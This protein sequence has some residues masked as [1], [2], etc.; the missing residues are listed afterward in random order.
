MSA[1]REREVSQQANRVAPLQGHWPTIDADFRDSKQF[2]L[3]HQFSGRSGPNLAVV[4]ER[5][6]II[7]HLYDV[8]TL[9]DSARG[10]SVR[11][12]SP[13]VAQIAISTRL[14]RPSLFNT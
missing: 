2:E 13:R 12:I 8:G 10:V 3:E 9:P 7:N 1:L 4:A 6:W 5:I 14:V 11:G